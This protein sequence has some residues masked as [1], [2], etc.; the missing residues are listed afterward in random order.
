MD[1]LPEEPLPWAVDLLKDAPVTA[2]LGAEAISFDPASE[3]FRFGFEGKPEFCN[4]LGVI[5]GGMVT[6]MLDTVMSFAALAALGPDFRVPTLE[7]KTT[8]LA[9]ARPGRLV[10]EGWP[11][12]TGKSICFMEGRLLD[13]DG[14]PIATAS[15]TARVWRVRG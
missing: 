12:R 8:Y 1:S 4:M 7:M 3:V 13:A 2:L 9:P 11:V 14:A 6:A 5:Q 15:G 10:G